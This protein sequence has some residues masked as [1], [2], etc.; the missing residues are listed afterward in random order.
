MFLRIGFILICL[1]PCLVSCQPD[2]HKEGLFSK[3]KSAGTNKNPNL[4]EASGL[5]VSVANPGYL[6]CH[7]DSGNPAELFLLDSL[8][9]TKKVFKLAGVKNRD[10]EDIALGPC[11]NPGAFCLYVGDIG[12]NLKRYPYKYI[13]R[14]PEPALNDPEEIIHFDTIVVKLPDEIRD[15]EAMMIDPVTK[16]LYLVSKHEKSVLLYE[17]ANPEHSDTVVAKIVGRIPHQHIVAA[18]LSP[19]GS[20]VLIKSYEYIYYWKKKGNESLSELLQTPGIKLPYDRE[21]Q[22]ESV[23]WARNGSGYYTLSENGKGERAKLY[24][25]K[26]KKVVD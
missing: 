7:N 9:K 5:A 2:Q 12:D 1:C 10:W 13:Y 8:A 25:Y 19:D 23:A 4:E 20:E 3:G 26:R 14:V 6:W 16:N 18:D 24:F 11:G 21:I 22:G 17:V 15:S